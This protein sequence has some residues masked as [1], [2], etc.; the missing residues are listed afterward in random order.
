MDGNLTDKIQRVQ[1]D[2][3]NMSNELKLMCTKMS[4]EIR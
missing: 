1:G 2:F 3:E 4:S